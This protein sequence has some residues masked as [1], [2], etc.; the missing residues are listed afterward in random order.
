MKE[1][2]AELANKLKITDE[3]DVE[4]YLGVKVER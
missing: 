4:E 3:G 2:I 1:A